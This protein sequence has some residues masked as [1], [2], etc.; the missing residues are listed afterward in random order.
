MS[1]TTHV[2]LALLATVTRARLAT[3]RA[4]EDLAATTR[5]PEAKSRS[6]PES[7]SWRD[8]G[9][10]APSWNQHVP[11]YCGA[12][13]AFGTAHAL[14]DRLK[15]A[16]A[17]AQTDLYRGPDLLVAVQVLLNCGGE[18]SGWGRAGNCHE[19]GSATGAY[20]W[21]KRFGGWPSAT[22]FPYQA[23]D[24]LGCR[25]DTICRNC[26]PTTGGDHAC[27]AVPGD[28]ADA[29]PCDNGGSCATSPY[30]RVAVGAHGAL[31]GSA[32]VGAQAAAEAI[33][34]E[35]ARAGPVTCNLDAG[36]L[37]AY[38]SGIANANPPAGRGANDTDH[39][40]EVVG[41]GVDDGTPYWEIRNSWGEYWGDA[42]F[43]RV[44]RGVDDSMIESSCTWA[45]IGGWGAPGATWQ[46]AAASDDG[47]D[48]I[49][50]VHA[51]AP[52]AW[53]PVRGGAD[54]VRLAL[55]VVVVAAVAAVVLRRRAVHAPATSFGP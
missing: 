41:W 11:Q 36:P 43:G 24:G 31:P 33:Q 25:G 21:A 1:L 35:V 13:F 16:R 6:L 50:F 27:W 40:V 30:P 54:P 20:A 22:C 18:D 23:Q 28:A 2:L 52:W 15:I 55:L 45:E 5:P 53:E 47:M 19:G 29:Q 8:H 37:M 17:R 12:C 48:A 26:M 39:V 14:Q 34:R 32:A 7:F 44:L 9:L 10:L 42:G 38:T 3:V 46:E 49:A 51:P 4:H